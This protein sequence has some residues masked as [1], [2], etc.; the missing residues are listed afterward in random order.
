MKLSDCAAF[1]GIDWGDQQHAYCVADAESHDLTHGRLEHETGAIVEWVN[2]L[3]QR[4]P[5]K[6][7]A[8]CLEQR[9]GPLIYCLMQFDHLLLVP[10]NP[11]QLASF[12]T[13]VGALEAKDDPTDAG[14][15]TELVRKH[16][17][18]LRVW[19]PE[20]GHIRQL[21]LLA[22]Y[23][24][25]LVDERT[26]L[27][28]G[29]TD[30]LKQYFPLALEV[31]GSVLYSNLTYQF[32]SEY[33]ELEEL[34]NASDEELIDFY[35]TYKCTRKSV[36]DERLKKI[37]N[38][39]PLTTD[40]AIIDACVIRTKALVRQI[41]ATN[42]SIAEYESMIATVMSKLPD[43]EIIESFPGAGAA[44]ASRILAVMGTD[45]SRYSKAADIQQLSGI[46]PVVKR[47]GKFEVVHRR[48]ACNKF[49][50]Q[51]FH[52]YAAH[53]IKHSVW[54]KAYYDMSRAQ[55]KKHQ[56]V[57]RQLAFKWIRIIHACWRNHAK[58]DE[59]AYCG[60]LIS[61]KSPVVK[62]FADQ[63]NNETP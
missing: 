57:I 17:E 19:Q 1:V 51:T 55:G 16:G 21:R 45:R 42:L 44:M 3:R 24:R 7:I 48:W 20:D 29:L 50:L 30:T 40:R 56:A 4:F 15:L 11:K 33:R 5:G 38:S 28:N 36:I 62:F 12:R 35:R 26:R 22:E 34:Q 41:Q 23:R 39:L 14:L 60:S 53:S 47:S 61:R 37:R 49:V 63:K 8:V 2:K 13:A 46:A 18:R 52:E 58:Y 9:R 59:L 6:K 43:A 54:A 32:L 10:V 31:G 25:H 27:T